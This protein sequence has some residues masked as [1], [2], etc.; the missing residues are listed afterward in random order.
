VWKNSLPALERRLGS[1]ARTICNWARTFRRAFFQSEGAD[2]TQEMT[3]EESVAEM[4][5]A[6]A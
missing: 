3:H 4:R 5:P 1:D 6:A 2:V